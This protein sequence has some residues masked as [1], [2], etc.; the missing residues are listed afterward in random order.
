M[1]ARNIPWLAIKA[2]AALALPELLPAP[3]L[4]AWVEATTTHFRIFADTQESDVGKLATDL[5]RFDAVMRRYLTVPDTPEALA[6]PVTIYVT[7]DISALRRLYGRSDSAVAGF[8][9]AQFARPVAFTPAHAGQGS[10]RD[11]NPGIIL[12]HEYAHHF[13][14]QNSG[15]AY[16]YWFGEGY[17]EFVSTVD[18]DD[19]YANVGRYALHRY[20]ELFYGQDPTIRQLFDPPSG[21]D[22]NVYARGWLLTHFILFNPER[23]AQFAQYLEYFNAGVP[24]G[25][26]AERAFG[27]LDILNNQLDSY[28]DRRTF[29]A[30]SI[31]L[32]ALPTPTVSFRKLG[33]GAAAMVE[34]RMAST[35]GV[36]TQ[37]GAALYAEAAPVAARFPDDAEAQGWFAEIAFDAQQYDVADAAADRALAGNPK[38]TQAL[39]YKARVAMRQAGRQAGGVER[40]AR[41][42]SARQCAGERQSRRAV[43]ILSEF[44]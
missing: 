19:K 4:A 22:V 26:A 9:N 8:Y 37:S 18:F 36:D 29:P 13:L 34:F 40:G 35:R 33:A 32:T 20:N 2:A 21:G 15:I 10:K 43:P 38:S 5:E 31:A 11:L 27:S 1:K 17:A 41:L 23:K 28:R 3:A 24:P 30:L 42:Y 16:P 44:S 25:E 7:K 6:N 14:L 12:F 39:L